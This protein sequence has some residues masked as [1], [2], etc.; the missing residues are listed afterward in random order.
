MFWI[1]PS[2]QWFDQLGIQ[3]HMQ[4]VCLSIKNDEQHKI[5]SHLYAWQIC[6]KQKKKQKNLHFIHTHQQQWKLKLNVKQVMFLLA[7]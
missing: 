3:W 6:I 5:Q 2:A 4:K 7:N 1:L